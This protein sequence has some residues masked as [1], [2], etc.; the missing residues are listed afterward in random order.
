MALKKT[1]TWIITELPPGKKIISCKWVFAMKHNAD[2]SIK[3]LKAR[4]VVR[5]FTQSYGVDY[6]ET[7]APVAKLNTIRILLSLTANLDWPLHQLDIKNAF[8]NGDL[9]EEVCIKIPLGLHISND[10][11][12]VWKLL[13]SLSRL[14]P[15]PR[16]WFGR[17]S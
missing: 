14:K 2:G 9:E 12:K 4:L 15:S 7:F 16:V 17:F 13:K 3:R 5:G 10:N 1:G 11:D 6:Q 8:L